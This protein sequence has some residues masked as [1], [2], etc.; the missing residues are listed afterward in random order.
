M[1]FH[2]F[3][4]AWWTVW[5]AWALDYGTPGPLLYWAFAGLLVHLAIYKVFQLRHCGDEK[6]MQKASCALRNLCWHHRNVW[7][8]IIISVMLFWANVSFVHEIASGT[9]NFIYWRRPGT[10]CCDFLLIIKGRWIQSFLSLSFVSELAVIVIQS[11]ITNILTK[12]TVGEAISIHMYSTWRTQIFR[13]V[14]AIFPV[15][16]RVA[17]RLFIT[18]I[19]QTEHEISFNVNV[20]SVHLPIWHCRSWPCTL[21]TISR[22]SVPI[23]LR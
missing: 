1:E 21:S 12:I 8:S 11:C 6:H 20:Q 2:R 3:R 5:L 22:W 23:R 7:L 9:Y 4:R 18:N 14:K 13:L 17:Q 19:W 10:T 16:W 15:P